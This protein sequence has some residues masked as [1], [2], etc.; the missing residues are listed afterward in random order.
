MAIN[1]NEKLIAGFQKYLSEIES[2]IINS[3]NDKE[4]LVNKMRLKKLKESL[5]IIKKFKHKIT[6]GSDL[7]GIKGIGKGTII[8]INKI[9]NSD[10]NYEK[11]N[12]T[13]IAQIKKLELIYGIGQ[14]MAIKLHD[15]GIKNIAMLKKSPLL[16]TLPEQVRMGVKYYGVYENNIPRIEIEKV[17]RFLETE[18]KKID[19]QLILTVCG[20]FRRCNKKSNDIDILICHKKQRTKNLLLTNNYLQTFVNS[21][22]NTFLIDQLSFGPLKYSGFCKFENY[23]IRRIDIRYVAF[24]SYYTALLYFTGPAEFNINMRNIAKKNKYKLNEYGMYSF[25]ENGNPIKMKINSE[26]DIFKL[27]KIKYIHPCDR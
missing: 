25:T 10:S 23:P 4:L 27:L 21:L 17:K 19:N 20:S 3:K 18:I 11:N 22:K 8:R 1:D 16:Q 12:S 15:N 13:K 7:L 5:K 2:E 9:L 26:Y 24:N 14:K 6:K